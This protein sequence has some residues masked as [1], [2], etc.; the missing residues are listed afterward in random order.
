MVRYY[1]IGIKGG[2]PLVYF[3]MRWNLGEKCEDELNDIASPMVLAISLGCVI[4]CHSSQYV[5]QTDCPP[6]P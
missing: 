3:L 2:V 4:F 5:L 1:Q 6:Y